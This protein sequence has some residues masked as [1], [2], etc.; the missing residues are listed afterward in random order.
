MG[1]AKL[2]SLSNQGIEDGVKEFR[3]QNRYLI[4]KA[5]SRI[6]PVND[7]SKFSILD[8]EFLQ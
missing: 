8:S 4:H 2:N 7:C 6:L 3:S 1:S 5:V